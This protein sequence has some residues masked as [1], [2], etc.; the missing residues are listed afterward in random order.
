MLPRA[1]LWFNSVIPMNTFRATFSPLALALFLNRRQRRPD[2]DGGADDPR[3]AGMNKQG[4]GWGTR[5]ND[6]GGLQ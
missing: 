4:L 5:D 1:A 2:W 3:Y 6:R